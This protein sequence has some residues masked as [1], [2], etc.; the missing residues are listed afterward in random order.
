V[1][2]MWGVPVRCWPR[3]LVQGTK[4][5]ITGRQRHDTGDTRGLAL[6]AQSLAGVSDRLPGVAVG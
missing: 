1:K 4:G 6:Q 5:E 2:G 3:S